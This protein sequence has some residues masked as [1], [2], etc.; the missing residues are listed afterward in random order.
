MSI[1]ELKT[2]IIGVAVLAISL[3]LKLYLLNIKHLEPIEYGELVVDERVDKCYKILKENP[4]LRKIE[5]IDP[6]CHRYIINFRNR[7]FYLHHL[8]SFGQS[9]NKSDYQNI[10]TKAG[11]VINTQYGAI[12]LLP[13]LIAKGAGPMYVQRF[14]MLNLAV[15]SIATGLLL[16]YAHKERLITSVETNISLLITSILILSTNS[17]Q[18]ILSPGFGFLR[19]LPISATYLAYMSYFERKNRKKTSSFKIYLIMTSIYMLT[20]IQFELIIMMSMMM[21]ITTLVTCKRYLRNK[22]AIDIRKQVNIMSILVIS[23]VTSIGI[24][25][26]YLLISG[27]FGDIFKSTS[28][29]SIF[30]FNHSLSLG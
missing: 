2:I 29:D 3:T 13:S 28:G 22:L 7:G 15:G 25:L 24:K 18:F 8:R 27:K 16:I 9:L 20:S 23:L 1:K 14:G 4:S 11:A 30:Q 19:M 6:D 17:A 10:I 12:S 21:S 26:S 5:I